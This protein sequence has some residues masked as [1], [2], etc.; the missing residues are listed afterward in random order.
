MQANIFVSMEHKKITMKKVVRAVKILPF[1]WDVT[2][3]NLT[4]TR[5]SVTETVSHFL[6]SL[7]VN[8]EII[9]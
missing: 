4:G 6:Q 9:F 1:I 7:Q 2:V 5:T 3:L 8:A